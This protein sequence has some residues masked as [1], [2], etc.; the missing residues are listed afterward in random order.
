MWTLAAVMVGIVLGLAPGRV[1]VIVTLGAGTV[2]MLIAVGQFV[3]G[4]W[5]GAVLSMVAW[6][7]VAML[8]S[9][10]VERLTGRTPSDPMDED[11]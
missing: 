2:A 9:M 11:E 8:T 4:D 10:M 6:L 1:N 3:T 5:V 7:P